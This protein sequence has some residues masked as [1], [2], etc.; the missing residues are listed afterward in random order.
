MEASG[1][2]GDSD[3]GRVHQ[4]DDHSARS[5]LIAQPG[6]FMQNDIYYMAG[7]NL[8]IIPSTTSATLEVGYYSY[9]P[10]LKNNE[11]FWLL[12]LCPYAII[13]EAAAI[14]FE[15]IGDTQAAAG[16]RKTGTDLLR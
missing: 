1:R 15:S 11:T 7:T 4:V 14:V 2:S 9:A 5:H 13:H 12:D 16:N 8:V 6:S 10:A 3:T